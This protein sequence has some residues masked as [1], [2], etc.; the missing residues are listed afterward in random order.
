MTFLSLRVSNLYGP[1]QYG[2]R[3]QGIVATAIWR[4]LK[5]EALELWGSGSAVRDYVYVQDVARAFACATAYAGASEIVNVGSGIG[6]TVRDVIQCVE[7][8]L[9]EPIEVKWRPSRRTDVPRNVLKVSR[10]RELLGWAALT[11][12]EAGV[13][14][15]IDWSRAV[16]A[17]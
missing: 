3:G 17:L 16:L 10:A 6:H 7:R 14:K 13:K 9:R 15:S 1:G 4:S 11:S 5:G 2:D 12:F 8:V